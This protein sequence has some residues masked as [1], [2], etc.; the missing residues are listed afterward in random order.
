MAAGTKTSL[1]VGLRKEQRISACKPVIVSGEDEFGNPFSL[2]TFTLEIAARGVRLRGL[3][4]VRV[5]SILLLEV[6]NESARYRVVW[7]GEKGTRHDGH[8]GLESMDRDKSIFGLSLP[9]PGRF[10]DEYQRVAAELHR[11]ESRYKNLFENSL[12]LICT[13]DLDGR[14]LSVN[15]A[16]ALALGY[17]PNEALGKSLADFL[18]PSVRKSFPCYLDRIRN[19]GRD[20]GC[21]LV[22]ARDRKKHAWLY[23]NS[24]LREDGVPPYVVGHAMDVTE[25][26]KTEYKL[27]TALKK[28]Q[29]ALAEVTTLR[30]LLPICAWC[31]R[32]H[33]E[34]RTWSEFETYV[35]TQSSSRFSHG[36]CPQCAR[37]FRSSPG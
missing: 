28:L 16:A 27:Q 6:A 11:S 4:P 22:V 30:S 13:H 35:T 36:I 24:L 10:H 23:R 29:S 19:L 15:P 26:K 5:G 8:V 31:K 33:N 7:V 2:N 21:M 12:G 14:L 32:I 9:E 18:A 37:R 20:S 3:P 34:D 1:A 17:E 25:Q